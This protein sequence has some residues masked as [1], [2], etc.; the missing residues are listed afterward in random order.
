MQIRY[1][2]VLIMFA[3]VNASVDRSKIALIGDVLR[4]FGEVRIRVTGSSMLPSVWP[5]DQ[6]TIRRRLVTETRTGDIAVF[7]RDHR[8]FAHRVVAHEGRRLVTQGDGVPSRDEPVN[9]TELL[10]VVVSVARNGK[11]AGLPAGPGVAGRLA[12]ALVRRSS[13]ASRILQR[14]HALLGR[15]RVG[16][17]KIELDS[18]RSE[19]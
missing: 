3:D 17:S 16:S 6:L 18:L 11:R 15:V 4:R 5:G 12:A 13:H 9:E 19:I 8:L 2:T 10:G 7:T 14:G 1:Q